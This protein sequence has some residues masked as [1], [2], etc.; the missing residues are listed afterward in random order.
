MQ[1]RKNF[2]WLSKDASLVIGTDANSHRELFRAVLGNRRPSGEA[3]LLLEEPCET[4]VNHNWLNLTT[5]ATKNSLSEAKV[6]H[7]FLIEFLKTRPSGKCSTVKR[8]E[9]WHVTY[10]NRNRAGFD[11]TCSESPKYTGLIMNRC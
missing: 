4:L 10:A 7:N 3:R 5:T 6:K 2:N 9:A 8:T 11:Q 1:R